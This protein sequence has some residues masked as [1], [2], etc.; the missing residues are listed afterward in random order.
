MERARSWIITIGLCA[1]LT[2][3]GYSLAA[4]RNV[5]DTAEFALVKTS[6]DI[7]LYERWYPLTPEKKAR[8]VKATFTIRAEVHA[9][10]ALIKD[11]SR[12]LLWNKH[13]NAYKVLSGGENTWICYIQYDLPW[14]VSNQDCVLEYY[15]NDCEDSFQV[16]FRAV[17]HPLFPV[18][19]RI[20][21]IPDVSG[22]WIF[23]KKDS[24]VTVEYYITTTPSTTLPSWLTDPIIRNNLIETMSSFRHILETS[25]TR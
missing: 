17:D 20:Q 13:T 8:E 18:Q 22:K 4:Y 16:M 1:A 3:P 5:A 7:A 25:S 14:P 11:Q 23:K 2:L 10:A 9:A 15:Q 6:G 24:G 12:A 21:R 19:N